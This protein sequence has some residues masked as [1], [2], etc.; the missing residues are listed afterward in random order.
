MRTTTMSAAEGSCP[1]DDRSTGPGA[2]R[3]R[4]RMLL[5]AF[6]RPGFYQY[7]QLATLVAIVNAALFVHGVMAGWWW[8]PD[9]PALAAMSGVA[10][11]NIALGVMMRQQRIV[12]ALFWIAT[13]I[14]VSWPLWIRWTAGKVYNIGG[15]H[16]GATVAGSMWFAAF[17]VGTIWSAL[18]PSGPVS[19]E[20]AGASMAIVALLV[21]IIATS[22]GPLRERRHDLFERVHRFG[23]WSVLALFWIQGALFARDA[24]QAFVG[25]ASFWALV[26][27][28][29]SIVLPWLHLKRVPV[30]IER[31]SGHA[32]ILRLDYGRDAFPGSWSAISRNPLV[33]WHPFASIPSPGR[34]DHRLI[35]S[36]AGD[37]TGSFIDDMPSHVW[38]KGVATAGAAYVGQMFDRVVF[39]CTG[40]GI[41]PILPHLLARET[42]CTMIWATREPR[43]TYGDALVDEIE[44]ACPSALIWDTDARGKPDLPALAL[45]VAERFG[46]EA[47]VCISNQKLSWKVVSHL[48]NHGLPAFAPVWDS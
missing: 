44:A 48:E 10:M 24:G 42:P 17:T 35:V 46:A 9:G 26:L 23:G 20:T 32:A 5:R 45:E 43:K 31:P 33:E 37:W 13:R 12:N 34:D 1:A 47:V 36:R 38:V 25:S 15:I 14:P 41:G 4:P 6:T 29:F 39:V 27:I 7:R 11:A 40:S 8:R 21:L 2:G 16:S 22:I 28:T 3:R 18:D 19:M 30:E